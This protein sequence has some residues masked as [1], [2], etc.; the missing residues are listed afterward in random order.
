MSNDKGGYRVQIHKMVAAAEREQRS[1]VFILFIFLG[2]NKK[3]G[4]ENFT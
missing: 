1:H 3:H 2:G 4:G